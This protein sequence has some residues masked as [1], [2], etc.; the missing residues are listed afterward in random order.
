MTALT[1]FTIYLYIKNIQFLSCILKL[2]FYSQGGSFELK[3]L[4]LKGLL[5][6]IGDSLRDYLSTVG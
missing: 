1:F 4:F 6:C 3:H 5:L 2:L